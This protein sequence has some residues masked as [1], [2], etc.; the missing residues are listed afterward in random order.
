[1][2]RKNGDGM[3]NNKNRFERFTNSSPRLCRG[4]LTIFFGI[5]GAGSV[6]ILGGIVAIIGKLLLGKEL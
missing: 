3:T 1:M 6:A 2:D 5:V 4:Y